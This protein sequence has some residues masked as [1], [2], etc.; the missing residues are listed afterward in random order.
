[1]RELYV[2]HCLLASEGSIAGVVELV[3][4]GHGGGHGIKCL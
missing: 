3:G 1:M 4:R 2:K